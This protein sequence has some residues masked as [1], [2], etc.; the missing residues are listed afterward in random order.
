V[1]RVGASRLFDLSRVLEVSIAYF[2]DN[3]PDRTLGGP[4]ALDS[5]PKGMSENLEPYDPRPSAESEVDEAMQLFRGLEDPS[6]R[7]R[8]LDLMRALQE[9][10][11]RTGRS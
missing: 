4:G 3:M 5:R 1:N 6:V 11:R 10:R 2:F 9:P 8:L 7:A